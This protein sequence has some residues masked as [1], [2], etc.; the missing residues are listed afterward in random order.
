[1][2]IQNPRKSLSFS[3]SDAQIIEQFKASFLDN[4]EGN[5]FKYC[6]NVI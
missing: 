3:N 6:L 5:F 2:S 1:M 4:D